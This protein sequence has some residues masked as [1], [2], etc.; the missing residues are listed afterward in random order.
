[1][2]KDCPNCG[3]VNPPE[4][5]RCDCRYDFKGAERRLVAQ[6]HDTEAAHRAVSDLGRM[7][8]NALRKAGEKKMLSGAMWCVGGI[9]VTALTYQAAASRPGGGTYIITWGAI[10]FGAI[11]FVRGLMQLSGR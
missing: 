1:M 11:Q 7:R 10:V 8:S 2:V 6:G 3:L 4:A 9:I 5:A